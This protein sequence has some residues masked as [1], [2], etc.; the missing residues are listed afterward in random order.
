MGRLTFSMS[1]S[2]DGFVND[3]AGSLD[4]VLVDDEVHRSFNDDARS[5]GASLYGTRMWELMSSYWPTADQD[6]EATPAML[7]FAQIWATTPKIVFSS[8]LETVEHGARLVRGD[9]VDE[10]RRLRAEPGLDMDTGGPTMTAP[11]I[12]AGLVDEFRLYLTP[13]VLGGGTPFFP[14]G[15]SRFDL[16]LVESRPFSNGVTLL[17]YERR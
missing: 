12:E 1:V 3:E 5:M 15:V 13:V 6:P 10:V 9:V 14:R 16:R 8:S 7:D 17:R 2:L 4:W 11:L